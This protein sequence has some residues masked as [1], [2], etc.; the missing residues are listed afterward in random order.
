MATGEGPWTDPRYGGP[1]PLAIPQTRAELRSYLSAATGPGVASK[2]SLCPA[3]T[4]GQV[5]AHLAATFTRFAGQLAQS[6][7]G[8]LSPPFPPGR[9]TAENLRAVAAFTGDPAA[10]LQAEAERFLGMVTDPA[11]PM[12]HQRGP[13]PAG[14]Q[15][16][17]G[18][19]ELAVHHYDVTAP[20]G[21]AYRP[22]DPVPGLLADMF[23]RIG[24]LPGGAGPWDRVL[25]LT[26][27]NQPG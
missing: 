6:R 22:P 23:G 26:G 8:D 5:T 25:R 2:P 10:A 1:W 7:R 21:P 17:F 27:R 3:W 19:N 16:L 15:V 9:L 24:T 13:V 12:A 14:L 20:S 11:E 4:V 18:L